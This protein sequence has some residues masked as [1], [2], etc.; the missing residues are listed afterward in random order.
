[1]G[2]VT[3][4]GQRGALS[5][6]AFLRRGGVA[7]V[8]IAGGTLWTTAVTAG[9]ARRA[10]SSDGPLRHIVISG[11]E[12]RSFDHYFGFAP[13]VRAA[14]FG[15]GP[16]YTQPDAAGGTHAP[17]ELESPTSSD[18]PHDW[19]AVHEQHNG[20]KMDGFFTTTQRSNGDGTAAM[21]YYTAR[22]L[23][24]YYSLFER[25]GLCANYHCSVLGPT[26]PN[27]LY[28]MSGTSG[29][30]TVNGQPTG[31]LYDS[32][33]WPTILDLLEDAGVTWKIYTVGTDDYAT[34]DTDNVAVYWSRWAHDPRTVATKDDYLRDVAHGRLP[35]V[36]W[37]V[38]SFSDGF[39]E[40]PPASVAVGMGFQEE[41]IGALRRS[42][43]WHHSAFLL[44]YDEHG[45]FFDHVVPPQI[46]AFGLGVRVPLWVISPFARRGVFASHKPA[47]HASLLKFIERTFHLPTLASKNHAFD[48][49]TPTG[50]KYDTHGAPAPPRDGHDGLSDLYDLFRFS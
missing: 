34:G 35:Q 27:R 33:R 21:V 9:C 22:E 41:M 32:G 44:T 14:G 25:F 45:G 29:G 38:S 11:Q 42:D 48:H 16:G 12:N 49:A 7:G 8:T 31:P 13:Q 23:P 18:P 5:R 6:G 28:M 26:W 43:A 3:R 20:G 4:P 40:H 47:D 39:D 46:D 37:I 19:H 30:I 50:D 36:S 17:I 2:E 10:T 1:V 24:F 15:P